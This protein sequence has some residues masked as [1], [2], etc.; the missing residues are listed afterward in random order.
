M[1]IPRTLFALIAIAL[2]LLAQDVPTV[3]AEKAASRVVVRVV[4]NPATRHVGTRVRHYRAARPVTIA[5]APRGDERT[6]PS[7]APARRIYLRR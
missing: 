6:K 5:A 3:H 1:S 4:R 7:V 2:P